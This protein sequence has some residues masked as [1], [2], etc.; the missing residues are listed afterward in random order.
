MNLYVTVTVTGKINLVIFLVRRKI[1]NIRK[2]F[3]NVEKLEL[4]NIFP[5]IITR[6]T[7]QTS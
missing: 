2:K 1:Y 6:D 3:M 5:L 4:Y 7:Q